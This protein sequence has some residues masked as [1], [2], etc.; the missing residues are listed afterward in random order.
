MNRNG[1]IRWVWMATLMAASLVEAAENDPT[2]DAAVRRIRYAFNVRNER[3]EVAPAAEVRIYAPVPRAAEQKLENLTASAPFQ[4]KQDAL[5]NEILTFDFAKLPPFAE[6]EVRI[7][8]T[9]GAP[10]PAIAPDTP[11]KAFLEAAP[12]IEANHPDIKKQAATLRSPKRIFAWVNGNLKSTGPSGRAKGAF[13]ALKN[14]RG[15]CTEYACLFV[16]LC[17]AAG[18]PARVMSGYV[19]DKDMVIAPQAYHNWAEFYDGSRWVTADPQRN[20]FDKA[21]RGYIAFSV[22]GPGSE[23]GMDGFSRAH[24][25]AVGVKVTLVK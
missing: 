2:P 23:K 18:I 21:C 12:Y 4:K 22:V 15:D 20:K 8:A 11:S 9:I 5:G 16:A 14:K 3:A 25:A 13:Y 7:E 10:S 6:R 19:C 1:K 24:C 17:R